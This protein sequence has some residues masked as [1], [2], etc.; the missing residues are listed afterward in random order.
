MSAA[1]A[2]ELLSQESLARD[3]RALLVQYAAADHEQRELRDTFLVALFVGPEA[4]SR[5]GPPDHFTASA[6][7]FDADLQRVCLVL[8]KK[9]GRWLQPGGHF[10]SVDQTVASAALREATEETGLP[11]LVVGAEL[12]DL[13]HHELNSKFGRCRSH[14]DL[15][16]ACVAPKGVRPEVSAESDDVRWWPVEALPDETD[17]ALRS[18]IPAIRDTLRR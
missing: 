3:A 10:E 2:G 15:R 4:M 12:V 5:G 16:F 18:T 6:F 14:L 7:V 13:S 17:E 11:D 8:H 1:A 9:A